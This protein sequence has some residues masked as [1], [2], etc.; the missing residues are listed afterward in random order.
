MHSSMSRNKEVFPESE[1]PTQP[2]ESVILIKDTPVYCVVA[3]AISKINVKKDGLLR[4]GVKIRVG[5]AYEIET[6]FVDAEKFDFVPIRLSERSDERKK[7]YI[8]V[9]DLP[10]NW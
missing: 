9:A 8:R 10:M 2:A 4:R 7:I 1:Y 3:V 6:L 5:S